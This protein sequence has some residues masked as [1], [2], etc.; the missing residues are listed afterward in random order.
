MG[1]DE[2]NDY[3]NAWWCIPRPSS[4]LDGVHGNKWLPFWFCFVFDAWMRASR[5]GTDRCS[6]YLTIIFPIVNTFRLYPYSIGVFFNN[7]HLNGFF[8]PSP[9]KS[10]E[11]RHESKASP[12]GTCTRVCFRL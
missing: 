2:I 4:S 3:E 1:V 6:H 10:Q 7:V 12:N 9:S 8:F 5:G 11:T